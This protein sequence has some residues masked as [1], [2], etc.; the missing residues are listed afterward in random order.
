MARQAIMQANVV[1]YSYHYLLDPK[2]AEM[3]SKEL[4]K[5]G[6]NFVGRSLLHESEEVD[7]ELLSLLLLS[8]LLS[9]LLLSLS[10]LLTLTIQPQE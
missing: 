7:F 10:L 2:I 5:K 8:L 6:K 9:L 4:A 3:V 1:V